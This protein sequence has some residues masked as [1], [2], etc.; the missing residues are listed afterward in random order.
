MEAIYGAV[1]CWTGVENVDTQVQS[2][3]STAMR[4]KVTQNSVAVE[5]RGRSYMNAAICDILEL[6]LLLAPFLVFSAIVGCDKRNEIE[7]QN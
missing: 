5:C 3:Y 4:E 1:G 7:G 2:E 6:L